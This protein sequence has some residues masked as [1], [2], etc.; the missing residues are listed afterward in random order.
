MDI[1]TL[2]KVEIDSYVLPT[3]GSYTAY[4]DMDIDKYAKKYGNIN[5]EIIVKVYSPEKLSEGELT[6]VYATLEEIWGQ[7][8]CRLEFSIESFKWLKWMALVEGAIIAGMV[9]SDLIPIYPMSNLGIYF[10]VVIDV[11]F[12]GALIFGPVTLAGVRVLTH[13]GKEKRGQLMVKKWMKTSAIEGTNK[14]LHEMVKILNRYWLKLDGREIEI[15]KAM[16][17]Y[18]KN[19]SYE[20]PYKFYK[21]KIEEIEKGKSFHL[22]Y[23][24]TTLAGK[25][26]NIFLG[27]K[28]ESPIIQL[29]MRAMEDNRGVRDE[30]KS[31]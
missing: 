11:F 2:N 31:I 15:Y 8:L 4:V 7:Y 9:A 17:D 14:D 29:P 16:R 21:F 27:P 13:Y 19:Q 28:I 30:N 20:S 1:V 18:C 25:L 24:P 5:S 3:I 6:E 26:R 22:K 12:W 10:R 23:R